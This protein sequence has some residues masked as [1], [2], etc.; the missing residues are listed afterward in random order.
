[1]RH[2]WISDHPSDVGSNHNCESRPLAAP[3]PHAAM[4]GHA[5]CG[6]VTAVVSKDTVT[7]N[8]ELLVDNIVPAVEATRNSA[9]NLS[10]DELIAAAIRA[11]VFQSMADLQSR[12]KSLDAAVKANQLTI[13][14]ALYDLKTGKV[15]WLTK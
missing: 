4:M 5:K 13:V 12:S 3:A 14:G 1:M 8:A 9:P 7:P 11:N 15:E 6:A 10:G 2:L